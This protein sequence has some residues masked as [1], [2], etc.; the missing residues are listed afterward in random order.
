MANTFRGFM[1]T[2]N[3]VLF[4]FF[5]LAIEIYFFNLLT[6]DGMLLHFKIF[7]INSL[8]INTWYLV[9]LSN[10]QGYTD[11]ECNC[12]HFLSLDKPIYVEQFI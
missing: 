7:G 9:L 10:P 1:T 3:N 8:D 6:K 5:I 12:V 4:S 11:E 2:A